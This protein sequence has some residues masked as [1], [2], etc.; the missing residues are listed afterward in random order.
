MLL[1]R[2]GVLD[3][4]RRLASGTERVQPQPIPGTILPALNRTGRRVVLGI[5]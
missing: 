3:A 5:L 1:E 2:E 4:L